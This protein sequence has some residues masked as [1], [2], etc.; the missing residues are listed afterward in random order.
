VA[1][2]DRGP[3]AFLKPTTISEVVWREKITFSALN[4]RS[5]WFVLLV[6]IPLN[7]AA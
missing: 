7:V 5:K 3:K 2:D 6:A 4:G 1:F